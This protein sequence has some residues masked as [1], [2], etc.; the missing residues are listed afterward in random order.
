MNLQVLF[1]LVVEIGL[2]FLIWNRHLRWVMICGSVLLHTGIGLFM[3][4]VTF[5]LMMLAM[6]LAF[7]PPEVVRRTLAALKDQSRQ[8]FPDRR[9]PAARSQPVVLSR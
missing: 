5:S 8:F 6:L 9:Q 2:P 7:V 3:G 4:L 1:T